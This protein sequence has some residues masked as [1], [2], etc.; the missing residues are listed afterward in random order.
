[1]ELEQAPAPPEGA[2]AKRTGG[3]AGRDLRAAIGV[4]VGLGAAVLA[5]LY[6]YRPAF[7]GVLAVAVCFGLY[8]L[9][10]ALQTIGRR[11]PLPPIWA[12]GVA[13]LLL[14][15]EAGAGAL[16]LALLLVIAAVAVW[17]LPAGARGYLPDVS[18]AALAVTY[19]P[20]LA[21][22]AALL[23]RSGDGASR[24]VTFIATVVCSDVGG[25]TAGVA[26]GRHPM[27][28]TV[29]P[30]KSWEG[31]AGSAVAC[32]AGGAALVNL[33]LDAPLWH[34]AVFGLAIVC[35]ATIGDLGESMIKRDL[36]VKDMGTLLP[37]HGG[38]MDR[39]DSLLP[40]AP[41]AWLVLAALVPVH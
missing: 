21:G 29:S 28:P 13:M 30:K 35:S 5:T 11:V 17:R 34:G 19:V 15:Y 33:L 27:A 3:R 38:V 10:K 22:F 37:G 20:F 31:L 32:A 12:G 24:V 18:A 2:P 14:A 1:M 4:G 25:Y 7:L 39:L 26:L 6:G 8:E 9:V 41:V 40:S 36:T 16:L 23:L